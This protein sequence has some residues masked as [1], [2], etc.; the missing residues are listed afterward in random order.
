MNDEI[1]PT[2]A[3][4][5]RLADGS[6]PVGERE[7]LR[8]RAASSP[9]LAAARDEQARAVALLRSTDEVVASAAL[10]ASVQGISDGAAFRA[11]ER[12]PNRLPLAGSRRRHSL[13]MP[14]ATAL[15]IV[16][17]AVVVK[18]G[19]TGTPT[20]G[21]T[22]RLALAPAMAPAPRPDA[23]DRRL[24]ALRVG[25]V[26]FPSYVRTLGWDAIGARR[27][28]LHGRRVTTV[29]Y[30]ARDGTRVGYAIVAGRML[31]DPSGPSQTIHGVRYVLGTVG[32][33]RLV[34]WWRDGHTCVI[35][36]P[37]VGDATLLA[38]AT[39]DERVD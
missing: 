16:V 4:L 33:A 7:S 23:S 1:T 26:P 17:A 6:L 27:D 39:A 37:R 24:L 11:R 14:A 22:A 10:R 29:F 2:D 13:F 38:L 15:A 19:G 30:R 3:Q 34:T 21:Q 25:D 35:A 20:V 31:A 5:A 18:A 36:G 28:T 8:E 32:S 9:E 12:G